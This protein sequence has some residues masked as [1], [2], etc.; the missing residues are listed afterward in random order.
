[1]LGGFGL[2]RDS[3]LLHCCWEM[4]S[5]PVVIFFFLIFNWDLAVYSM[6]SNGKKTHGELSCAVG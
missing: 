6:D 5:G 3:G 1:M 2:H 4:I